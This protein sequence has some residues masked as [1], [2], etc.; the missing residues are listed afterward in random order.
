M[1]VLAGCGLI[2][3]YLLSH[4]AGQ[5]LGSMESAIYSIIGIMIVSMGCGSF[6]S[7]RF[8]RCY[9]VFACLEVSV[10]L[11]G[12]TS[13]LLLSALIAYANLLPQ[14]LAE[15]YGIAVNLLY[16]EGATSVIYK[17]AM[18]LPYFFGFVLGFL[19][20]M[21]IPLIARIRES[22]YEKH[23]E[24]NA[25]TIYGADYMGAGVGAALWVLLML[26]LEI[27]QAAALTASLNIIAGLL[28]IFRFRPKI[29]YFKELL[30]AHIFLIFVVF[31]VFVFG[32]NWQARLQDMLYLNTVVYQQ[33]T[34]H[35]N[36]VFTR[37]FMDGKVPDLIEFYINGNLQ[38]SSMDEHIYHEMLVHP[39]MMASARN[40]TILIIGG[41]DGLALRE[42]LKWQPKKVILV[43]FD[44]QLVDLFE[45]PH[46]LMPESLARQISEMN[47]RSLT[48]N[49]VTRVHQDAFIYMDQLLR[50][51]MLFDSI[52]VDLPD[53]SHP[54]LNKLY[55]VN[56]YTK[57]KSLLMGDGVLAVQSNSP[58]HAKS[59]FL[60]IG[61]TIKAA[62]FSGVDQ[63]HHNVPTFGQ[64]GWTLA[65]SFATSPR[66]KINLSQHSLPQTKWVTLSLI[67]AAFEFPIGFYDDYQN[68]KENHLNE[69]TI[70]RYHQ[71]AWGENG[72]FNM[73]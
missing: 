34:E 24:H 55:S 50:S 53:P 61:K 28:F 71:D 7:R 37:K 46:Q 21:E 36:L 43:D 57:L 38:F 13:I 54:D 8:K 63:Y 70:Y 59:V 11:L 19:L 10:A 31:S 51:A 30:L 68:I 1:A 20:G 41:G 47:Q 44:Q 29:G 73:E 17:T 27:N 65:T 6:F 45:D 26:K 35:Q 64:W 12:A 52:I 58:Y 48:D 40:D 25:G 5:V 2:Y 32:G 33:K 49:R 3:E 66:E 72:G 69:L 62:G 14:L 4:Y 23:L 39:A 42:V 16:Y 22:Y 60:S 9:F 67:N 18:L 15:H 56:F